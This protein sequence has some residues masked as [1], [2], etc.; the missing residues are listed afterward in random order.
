MNG[1]DTDRLLADAV[2]LI[3]A[4]SENPGGTEA[5]AV[6]VL[7]RLL[8]EIGARVAKSAVEPGRENLHATIGP[9]NGEPGLLFLGHSDVVPAGPGWSAPPFVTRVD[10]DRLI[11]RGATDMKGGLAAIIAAMRT[12]DHESLERPVS[13]LVTADEEDRATGIA[14]ELAH[15]LRGAA[16]ACVV[17]E[18]TNLDCVIGCRGAMNVIV[19]VHG[20]AAHAGNPDDGASAI[21]AAARIVEIVQRD[22]EKWREGERGLI[23]VPTWNVG[24]IDGGHGPSIVPDACRLVLDRRLMPG[25]SPEQIVADLMAAVTAAGVPN[26][27]ITVAAQIDMVMPGFLMRP[28]ADLVAAS[29]QAVEGA[30]QACAVTG[31]T[32]ACEGGYLASADAVPT[33]ILGPGEIEE[34][35]H[36]PDESVSIAQLG[37]AS[38]AYLELMQRLCCSA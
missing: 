32:A 14:H 20:L 38:V 24:L 2:S 19:T 23:G 35:A 5:A 11:G 1:I 21:V 4:P 30:G 7:E 37:R 10:G 6:A 26:D 36:R 28:D 33:V 15:P 31:W 29:V 25:D 13:I 27:T 22:H 3:E 8:G 9:D 17:A 34:Q 16:L 18:P 12:I